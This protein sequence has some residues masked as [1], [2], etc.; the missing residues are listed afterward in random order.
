MQ[1][2]DRWDAKKLLETSGYCWQSFTLQA[3]VKLDIFTAIGDSAVKGADLA[4]KLDADPRGLAMLL[5]ALAAMGLVNKKGASYENSEAGKR[6]LV[7]GSEEYVGYMIAHFQHTVSAWTRLAEFVSTGKAALAEHD[8]TE[9][10]RE[11]FLMGMHTLASAVARNVASLIDLSACTHLLDLGGGPGTYAIHFCLA[12]PFLKATI[13]DRPES[14]PY[15]MGMIRKFA[16]PERIDF[17]GGN[18]LREEIPGTYDAAWMSHI[19]HGEGPEDC[20]K[21]LKKTVSALR[22]G[23]MVYVHDFILDDTLAQPLFPAIFSLN[24][25]VNTSKGQSYSE[26]Q[27]KTMLSESGVKEIRRLEIT[28]PNDSGI[29]CGRV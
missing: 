18:Y 25:L 28:G 2:E 7:K 15:A 21:I 1:K 9:A 12:N 4:K 26:S 22:P 11:N 16:L 23:G 24:M 13:Y 10:Q 3:G 19:L 14:E 29:I 8:M 6:F 5:N 17:A 20:I 27:I